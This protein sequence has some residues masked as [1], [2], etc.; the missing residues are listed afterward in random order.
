MLAPVVIVGLGEVGRP[1]LELASKHVRAFGVDV[2]PPSEDVGAAAVLHICYP[3][4]IDDFVGETARYIELF[5]PRLTIIDSTVAVGT[6]RAV[7]ERTGAAIVHSPVRGKH[8]QMLEELQRYTKFIGGI[9]TAAAALAAEH[10]E[11]LGLQTR[12][13]SSPEASELAK[14]TETSY[15]GFL[16]AW[17]QEVERYCDATGQDYDE[18]VSFYEEIP[19]FPPT[20]YFPGVIGGHCVMPNIEILRELEGS[21][22]LDVIEWSNTQKL[23]RESASSASRRPAARADRPN[24]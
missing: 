10:F 22:L 19:F 4:E 24:G 16:I 3:F 21:P 14:L 9:D 18:V 20:K 13:L 15:F 11:S 12:A 1:L 6:T 2:T 23:T 8:A 17:A 7:H 5:R